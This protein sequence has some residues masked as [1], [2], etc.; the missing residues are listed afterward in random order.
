MKRAAN[1][2][3]RNRPR[4]KSAAPVTTSATSTETPLAAGPPESDEEPHDFRNVNSFEGAASLVL[5]V[6][7]VISA[8]FPRSLKQLVMLSLGGGLV[9]RGMTGHCGVYE[10]LGINTAK[11]GLLAQ[12]NEKLLAPVSVGKP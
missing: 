8:L 1:P 4:K 7:F 10:A 2:S 6:L 5:G 3:A 9:Y 11:E 12:V